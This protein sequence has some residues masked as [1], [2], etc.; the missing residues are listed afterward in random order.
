MGK[1]SKTLQSEQ[2]L[3]AKGGGGGVKKWLGSF[4]GEGVS[5]GDIP[6]PLCFCFSII[7]VIS[8]ETILNFVLKVGYFPFI[9]RQ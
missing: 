8:N 7:N 6:A 2:T 4:L 5:Q 1:V 3:L 9:H